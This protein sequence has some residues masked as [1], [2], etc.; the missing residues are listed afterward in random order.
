ML[1]CELETLFVLPVLVV[2]P[3]ELGRLFGADP[4]P[5]LLPGPWVRTSVPRRVFPFDAVLTLEKVLG[6]EEALVLEEGAPG[7]LLPPEKGTVS[8]GA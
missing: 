7:L 1:S 4:D 3:L 8:V 6:L 5:A 2:P